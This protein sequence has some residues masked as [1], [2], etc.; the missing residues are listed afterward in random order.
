ML[1]SKN[2]AENEAGETNSK[3]LYIFEKMLNMR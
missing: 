1:F 3:P 2:C